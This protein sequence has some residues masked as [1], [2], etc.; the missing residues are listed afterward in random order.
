VL[1]APLTAAFD[2]EEERDKEWFEEFGFSSMTLGVR[3]PSRSI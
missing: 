1:R 2:V 3:P